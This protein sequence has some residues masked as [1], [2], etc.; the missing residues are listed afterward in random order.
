[1]GVVGT[2]C[3]GILGYNRGQSRCRKGKIL[4]LSNLSAR[5]AIQTIFRDITAWDIMIFFFF[6]NYTI[7]GHPITPLPQ[8][9]RSKLTKSFSQQTTQEFTCPFLQLP[10]SFLHTPPSSRLFRSQSRIPV[11]R[12]AHILSPHQ[13]SA[14][15]RVPRWPGA[16]RVRRPGLCSRGSAP[17]T[18]ARRSPHKEFSLELLPMTLT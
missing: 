15:L 14:H 8:I 10:S 3:P 4:P 12:D 2:C 7:H 16:A 17:H 18:S 13:V 6:E 9:P 1:M 5:R 11:A